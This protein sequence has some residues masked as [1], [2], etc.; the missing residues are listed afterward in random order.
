MPNKYFTT[1]I[2]STIIVGNYYHY[3][4]YFIVYGHI[5]NILIFIVTC[6]IITIISSNDL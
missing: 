4:N 2:V 1:F 3:Y 5:T 6:I